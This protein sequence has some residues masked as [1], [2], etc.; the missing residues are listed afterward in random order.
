MYFVDSM[1]VLGWIRS[2]ARS[3]KTFVSTRIREIQSNSDPAEW[4]NIPGEENVADDVPRGIL[5]QYKVYSRDGSP[6]P[7]SLRLVSSFPFF[8]RA[9]MHVKV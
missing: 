1:I 2:Q 4:K 7:T 3:F 5:Y 6:D 9:C 8:T